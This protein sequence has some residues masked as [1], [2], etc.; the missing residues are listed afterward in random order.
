[1]DKAEAELFSPLVGILK[2]NTASLAAMGAIF[3]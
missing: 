3:A 1:L 2:A